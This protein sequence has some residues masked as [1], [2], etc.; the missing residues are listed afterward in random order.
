LGIEIIPIG[1]KAD[2][3]DPC[4][5]INHANTIYHLGE[6]IMRQLEAIRIENDTPKFDF[7]RF[8]PYWSVKWVRVSLTIALAFSVHTCSGDSKTFLSTELFTF[9]VAAHR[10]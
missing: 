5:N 7:C 4:P 8:Y 3:S 6:G 10:F 9:W 2:P 1:D